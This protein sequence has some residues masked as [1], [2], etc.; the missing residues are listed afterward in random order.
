MV[1]GETFDFERGATLG[2]VNQVWETASADEF[3]DKI[4]KYAE[5]FC[6]PNRAAKAVGR[7]KR[8]VQSGAEVPFESALAIERELQQQ[9]FQSEDAKEGL[10]A[11]VEKRKANFTGR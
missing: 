7:I 8:S 2:I 4:Q 5:Q 1:T 10:A 3:F 9:L 11:Y 6:P